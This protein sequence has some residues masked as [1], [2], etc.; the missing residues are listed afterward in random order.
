MENINSIETNKIDPATALEV[1]KLIIAGKQDEIDNV[2]S[3][4]ENERAAYISHIMGLFAGA[5]LQNS[6]KDL[7]QEQTVLKAH[8]KQKSMRAGGYV[9]AT[10][11]AI[12]TVLFGA[13]CIAYLITGITGI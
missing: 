6:L 7:E 13:L 2:F 4:T 10:L 8:V 3:F 5:V 12:T 1:A 9:A 11:L